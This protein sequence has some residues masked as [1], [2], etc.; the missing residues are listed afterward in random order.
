MCVVLSLFDSFSLAQV[1]TVLASAAPGLRWKCRTEESLAEDRLVVATGP[2]TGR[3]RATEISTAA[4]RG[5]A[6]GTAEG[7]RRVTTEN[8][9]AGRKPKNP[10]L[11][12]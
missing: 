2:E 3:D 9:G 5:R 10:I 12:E 8:A 11:T 7:G 1:W 6:A 4:G